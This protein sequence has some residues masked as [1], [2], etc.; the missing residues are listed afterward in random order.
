MSELFANV[1]IP[2]EVSMSLAT[3]FGPFS[4][5]EVD[6]HAFEQYYQ[7]KTQTRQQSSSV[8]DET[9]KALSALCTWSENI[10]K[11][12]YSPSKG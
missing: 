9:D 4:P 7:W 11:V 2:Q 5:E 8:R 1:C 6:E 3:V 12:Y 10:G